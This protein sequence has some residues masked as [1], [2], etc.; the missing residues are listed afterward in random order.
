MHPSLIFSAAFSTVD[1][2]GKTIPVLVSPSVMTISFFTPSLF[3]NCIGQFKLFPADNRFM[4]VLHQV[5]V[6]LSPVLV[7]VKIAVRIGL[8]EQDV[9]RIL[10]IPDNGDG[11]RRPMSALLGSNATLFQFLR[12]LVGTFP[13]KRVRKVLWSSIFVTFRS[14]NSLC[15][16]CFKWRLPTII[17]MGTDMIIP[18]AHISPD[19][20]IQTFRTGKTVR[21]D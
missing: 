8:L 13:R 18:Y 6:K 20:F 4:V 12:N 21:I 15:M 10:F 2:A 9:T 7:S 11:T 19:C 16:S 14:K 3:Q 5:L 1:P 17:R